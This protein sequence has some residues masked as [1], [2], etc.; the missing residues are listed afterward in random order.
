MIFGHDYVATRTVT[1]YLMYQ[2]K[3]SMWKSV[4]VTTESSSPSLNDRSLS[5]RTVYLEM[6]FLCIIFKC[7][8]LSFPFVLFT[9]P[10]GWRTNICDGVDS[11]SMS[12]REIANS[13]FR[14]SS[15]EKERK[16]GFLPIGISRK[17]FCAFWLQDRSFEDRGN[18]QNDKFLFI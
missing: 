5:D 4:L 10:G 16:L 9:D 11:P 14:N 12:S 1:G 18:V 8:V 3:N 2:P 7:L 17:R 13:R 15:S 6:C